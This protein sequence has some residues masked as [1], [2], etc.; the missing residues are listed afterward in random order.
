M[1][2]R[3]SILITAARLFQMKGYSATGLN[4]ILSQSGSPK[5]SLYYY[6]PQGKLQLATEAVEYAGNIIN[7]HVAEQL[8]EEPN[9]VKAFQRVI[10]NIIQHFNERDPGFDDVSL[11]MIALESSSE[12]ESLRRACEAI[13]NKRETLFVDKLVACGYRDADA[14]RLGALMQVL[15]E[16][17]IIAT[18]T[19]SDTSVLATVSS[20]IPDLLIKQFV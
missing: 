14:R 10:G 16:G 7:G 19:R 6:F 13:F 9:E 20:Y 15:I 2:A 11:S 17:A 1:T 8:A 18:R 12:A 5:G 4:E 3:E